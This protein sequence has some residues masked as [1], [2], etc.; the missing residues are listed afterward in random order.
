MCRTRHQGILFS[1]HLHLG[2]GNSSSCVQ[3]AMEHVLEADMRFTTAKA[4]CLP[5]E[6]YTVNNWLLLDSYFHII[7][8]TV[9]YLCV[10]MPVCPVNSTYAD[11]SI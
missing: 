3:P 7:V 10:D 9:V 4:G 1:F 2:I 8:I 5:S 6:L 11:S